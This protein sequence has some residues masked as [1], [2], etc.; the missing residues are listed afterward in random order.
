M[1]ISKGR[2][3]SQ[4]QVNQ[5]NELRC[6][7]MEGIVFAGMLLF[8]GH[9]YAFPKTGRTGNSSGGRLRIAGASAGWVARLAELMGCRPMNCECLSTE[10]LV[11]G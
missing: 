6:R 8:A 7:G 1:D 3:K 4:Y 5:L 10:S 11:G 9:S 2:G